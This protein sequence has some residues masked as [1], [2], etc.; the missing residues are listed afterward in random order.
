MNFGNVGGSID[1]A[2]RKTYGCEAN[3]SNDSGNIDLQIDEQ[4]KQWQYRR[5]ALQNFKGNCPETV[6][7]GISHKDGHRRYLER[8][9]KSEQ[10]IE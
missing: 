7:A 1:I 6:C 5:K 10:K 8:I 4:N 2:I 9:E 3:F